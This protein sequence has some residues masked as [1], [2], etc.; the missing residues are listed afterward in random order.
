VASANVTVANTTV[1]SVSFSSGD[2]TLI[3]VS[4]STVTASPYNTYVSGLKSGST[5]LTAN[6]TTNPAVANCTTATAVTV[7]SG[8]WFQTQGGDVHSSGNLI[9]KIPSTA[10]SPNLSLDLNNYPGVISY[11]PYSQVYFGQGYPAK[12][13]AG[14]WMAASEYKGKPY[15]SFDFFKKKYALQMTSDNF[16]GTLPPADGVYYSSSGLNLSGSWTLGSGRWLVIIIDGDVNITS[17]IIVPNGS[18]LAIASSGKISFANTVAKAQGMF[19]AETIDTGE[20]T[21]AFEGQGIF[22][23]TNFNLNRDFA[24]IRNNTTPS[25]SFVARPDFLMSSYKNKD[26]NLWWYFQ[27]WQELA[28]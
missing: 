14:Y 5:T 8:A 2:S 21:M 7:E 18:F 24:D 20:G 15:G 27:K 9:D 22:A 1:T 10:T 25:E 26:E 19:V 23:A 6:V 11:K 13:T 4:P 17:D 3:G 12:G 16:N 28:P